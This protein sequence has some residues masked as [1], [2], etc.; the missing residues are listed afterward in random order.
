MR[1]VKLG[2][3]LSPESSSLVEKNEPLDEVEP[4]E[5]DNS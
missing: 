3:V 2:V 5:L 4:E 1:G